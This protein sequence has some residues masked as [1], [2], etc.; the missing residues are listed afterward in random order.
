MN[1]GGEADADA[2]EGFFGGAAAAG[3]AVALL[4]ATKKTH[5][6]ASGSQNMSA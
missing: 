5:A 1:A 3:Q 4:T 2:R 6:R